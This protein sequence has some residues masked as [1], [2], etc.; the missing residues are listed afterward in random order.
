MRYP[1][2]AIE[3]RVVHDS[4]E[5]ALDE[6]RPDLVGISSVTQNYAR[7]A[8]YAAVAKHRGVPVVCG[9]VHISMLPESLT[10]DMD[11]GVLGEGEEALCDL[12]ALFRSAGGLPRERLARIEGITFRAEG[13]SLIT[14]AARSPI[15]DLDS[16]PRP[17]RS[18]FRIDRDTSIFTSRGCPYTC[19]FCASSRFWKKT[20]F[21]SAD[22][23]VREIGYLHTAF[24]V[25]RIN[26][27]DDLFC[28]D[29]GRVKKIAQLLDQTGCRER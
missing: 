3:C 21:F 8:R 13:G 14:T 16:I 26:V 22:Y 11:V 10:G 23:V 6:F 28:A 17:D 5:R 19:S 18:L 4:V 29:V 27:Y 15:S 9:G 25:N 1:A 7:A 24:R 12:Y 20:R 2:D